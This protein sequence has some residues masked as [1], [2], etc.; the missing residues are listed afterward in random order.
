MKKRC[1][2]IYR[3]A[4]NNADLTQ[5]KAAELLNVSVRSLVD[6]ESGRT[7]PHE[8]IVCRMVEVYGAKWLGY[9]HLRQS[10]ELGKKVLPEINVDDLAKSVLILQKE[11][12]DVEDI[13]NN[14]V[15]IACDGVIEKNEENMWNIVT[16]E[17]LE[18]AGAALSVVYSR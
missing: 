11:S 6:Y 18:M 14:M 2:N 15:K 9:E 13:K 10:S 8:D 5:E 7:I 3:I 16:K 17:V 12:S 4:R 1:R